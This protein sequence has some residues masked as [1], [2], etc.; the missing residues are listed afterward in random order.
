MRKLNLPLSHFRCPH[1]HC[2]LSLE[3]IEVNG[4]FFLICR[5]CEIACRRPTIPAEEIPFQK[6]QIVDDAIK[7][8]YSKEG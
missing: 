1:N 4:D 5:N 3:T 6:V 7:N 8:L 2:R